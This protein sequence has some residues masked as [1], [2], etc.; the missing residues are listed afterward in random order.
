MENPHASFTDTG[1]TEL[2]LGEKEGSRRVSAET[3]HD[4]PS[5]AG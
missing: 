4:E 5:W 3:E 2:L 1:K